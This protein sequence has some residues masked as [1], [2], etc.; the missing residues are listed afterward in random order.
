M[1]PKNT[2]SSC[3][4][5][6]FQAVGANTVHCDNKAEANREKASVNSVESWLLA[7]WWMGDLGGP[8]KER[9]HKQA[10]LA[11]RPPLN[12]LLPRRHG[13]AQAL[14]RASVVLGATGA[15]SFS[16]CIGQ[17]LALRLTPRGT[18]CRGPVCFPCD[19]VGPPVETFRP[20]DGIPAEKNAC[21]AVRR[22]TKPR[23]V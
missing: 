3:S 16:G 5:C 7:G 8:P 10:R 9:R 23:P 18:S 2:G 19:G 17:S 22:R 11:G 14:A 1:A 13:Q 12:V 21:N 4:R 20:S 15:G 6:S